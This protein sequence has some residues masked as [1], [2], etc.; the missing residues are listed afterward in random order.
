MAL[1]W[2]ALPAHAA[3]INGNAYV[4]LTTIGR[5][6]GMSYHETVPDREAELRT[7]RTTLSFPLHKRWLFLN[8]E[9][10]FIGL[11]VALDRG[12]LMI[13]RRDYDTTIKPL[14]TPT[15]FSPIPKLYR[16]VIDPGHGGKDPGAENRGKATNEKILALD[17]AKRLARKLRSYG[18]K[19]ILTRETD[20]FVPL[21]SRPSVANKHKADLFVSI[22]F[23]AV[24][25][26]RV[27]GVETYVMTP[28]NLPSTNS[29]RMTASARRTYPGNKNDPWNL[30]AGFYLQT[31]MV[32]NLKADDRG[33]KRARFAVLRDLKCPGVLV[34]GGF[35]TN[36]QEAQQLK[37]IAYREKLANALLE[38]ILLYQK[39]LNIMRGK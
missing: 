27:S 33:L 36:A 9:R 2:L 11:P 34:E 15:R 19:V 28:P 7:G 32:R 23:N 10:I 17:V 30:L 29:G 22:H 26:A 12:T 37:S 25:D 24:S 39:K 20:K 16:I 5:E 31:A 18:Y 13:S 38:G 1:L 14:L 8:G 35:L 6:L 3:T 4:P 21:A